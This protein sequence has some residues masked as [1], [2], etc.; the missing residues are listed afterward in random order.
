MSVPAAYFA[1]VL[2]WSTTPLGI[3]WSSETVSPTIA[4]LMRMV[5]AAVLGLTLLKC[6]GM[7]LPGNKQAMKVYWFSALGIFGGMLCSYMAAAYISSGMMSL[8]FGLSPVVS[9]LLAQKILNEAKFS[10]TRKLAMLVSLSGLALVCSDNLSMTEQNPL[11]LIF[12]L[13]AVFFFSLSAVL[14][15]SVKVAIHPMATTVGALLVSI[16]L[17]FLAWL[18]LDG[19]M[20]VHEWQARSLWA[21]LYLGVFGSL[22]GFVAYYYVLQKLSAS[23]VTLITMIT[24]AIALSIGA[25]LNNETVSVNLIIGAVFVMSGLA[26]YNWGEK[27]L[28]GKRLA[29]KA[30]K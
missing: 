24:P 6:K 2:I 8:I 5:I 12:I 30:Q 26:I 3:V 7:S 19:T 25:Y 13:L 14:V 20:P 16:P 4:V 15:K 23:T 22:I 9:G 17:F 1:V 29:S 10:R 18:V 28:P 27:L 21:I 11:G